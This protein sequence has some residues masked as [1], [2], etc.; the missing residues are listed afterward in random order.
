MLFAVTEE[1]AHAYEN[2]NLNLRGAPMAMG[3]R[4]A[5]QPLVQ[6]LLV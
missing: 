2:L 1:H 5:T 6:L 4:L 3:K